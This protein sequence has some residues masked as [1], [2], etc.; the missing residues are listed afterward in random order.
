M[1][2]PITQISFKWWEYLLYITMTLYGLPILM[3][4][5]YKNLPQISFMSLPSSWWPC[6]LGSWVNWVPADISQLQSFVAPG[7]RRSHA[8]GRHSSYLCSSFSQ[9]MNR[10]MIVW[11]RTCGLES[12]WKSGIAFSAM[13]RN[14]IARFLSSLFHSIWRD[15]L[16]DVL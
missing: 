6:L 10:G 5:A 3:M 11:I 4:V 13:P 7:I 9:P 16:S 8:R 15:L 1:W 14:T 12:A 2:P